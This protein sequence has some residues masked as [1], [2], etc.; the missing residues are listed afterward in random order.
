MT[1]GADTPPPSPSPAEYPEPTILI[2]QVGRFTY[3]LTLRHMYLRVDPWYAIGSRAHAEA[4]ARRILAR[5]Y[6]G[7]LDR[8]VIAEVRLSDAEGDR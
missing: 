2:E 6:S 3:R 4:K 5:R 7:A 1:F 8:G